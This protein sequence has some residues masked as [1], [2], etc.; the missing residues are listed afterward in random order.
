MYNVHTFTNIPVSYISVNKFNFD[1]DKIGLA[2]GWTHG[3]KNDGSAWMWGDDQYGG[4]GINGAGGTDLCRSS[5]VSVVG[6]HSF[7]KI[8]Y[9]SGNQGNSGALKSNGQ[10]WGWGLN[11]VGNIGNNSNLHRSSPVAATGAHSFIDIAGYG[12]QMTG[13]NSYGLKADGS[14]WA[15]GMQIDGQLGNENANPSQARSSPVSVVGNHSFIFLVGGGGLKVDGSSW[16]WGYNTYGQLGDNTTAPKSSPV[17]V[18]GNHSFIYIVK[19]AYGS[20]AKKYDGTVWC[21]GGTVGSSEGTNGDNTNNPRS[22]PV[23][24]VG[25]HSFYKI[26]CCSNGVFGLKSDG[27]VWAWGNNTYGTVG[28]N[29]NINRSSPV[30]VVGN[31]SFVD[32]AQ[33]G[34]SFAYALKADGNIWSWGYNFRGYLGL[35]NHPNPNL[36]RSSPVMV[37]GQPYRGTGPFY[38]FNSKI[39]SDFDNGSEML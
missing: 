29:T 6:N 5:P 36:I 33:A 7:V 15:W 31:H 13:N 21:W 18:V 35:G 26:G 39:F 37:I 28:D 9:H 32:I 24:V 19:T 14:I 16:N 23:S 12:S 30:S 10:F 1:I 3:L 2:T 27:T 22:S 38:L 11:T 20:A 4:L 25:N 17:S 34:A 8:G